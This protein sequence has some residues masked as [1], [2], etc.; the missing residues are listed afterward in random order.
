M[1]KQFSIKRERP[2]SLA[3]PWILIFEKTKWIQLLPEFNSKAVTFY[4]NEYRVCRRMERGDWEERRGGGG[5][6]DWII[7][8]VA[9]VFKGGAGMLHT[10]G[11]TK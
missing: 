8:K 5:A 9:P 3:S 11:E 7:F 10:A 1:I 4:T 6:A 2:H